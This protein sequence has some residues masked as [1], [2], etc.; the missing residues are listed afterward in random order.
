MIKNLI[1]YL[2][3]TR[4]DTLATKYNKIYFEYNKAFLKS[5]VFR[6]NGNTFEWLWCVFANSFADCWG[7]LLADRKFLKRGVKLPGVLSLDSL[8][9]VGKEGIEAF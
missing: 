6:C 7:R 5:D 9:L 2:N 8:A 1:V 3:Y 4:L